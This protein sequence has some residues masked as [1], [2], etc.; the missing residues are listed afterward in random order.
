MTAPLEA[1]AQHPGQ[2]Q[3]KDH[4]QS[5]CQADD[6]Q[7]A[8]LVREVVDQPGDRDEVDPVADQQRRND[9]FNDAGTVDTEMMPDVGRV[10]RNHTVLI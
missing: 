5:P 8:R 4:R 10:R 9:A 1:V 7:R 2:Q 6:R 3:P